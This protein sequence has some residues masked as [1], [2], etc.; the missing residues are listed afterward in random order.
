MTDL[1][2]EAGSAAE[3][4]E[5]LDRFVKDG[6]KAARVAAV[7]ADIAREA[8]ELRSDSRIDDLMMFLCFSSRVAA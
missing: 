6:I 7:D 4:R 8:E 3:I 5:A 2:A 1:F